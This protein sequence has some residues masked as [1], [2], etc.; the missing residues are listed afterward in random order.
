MSDECYIL[1]GN[2]PKDLFKI[3]KSLQNED[4]KTFGESNISWKK[5]QKTLSFFEN[6]SNKNKIKPYFIG[7]SYINHINYI[8]NIF[9]CN[10]KKIFVH[11][12]FEK[13]F[14]D[15]SS[16]FGYKDNPFLNENNDV[17][18]NYSFKKSFSYKDYFKKYYLEIQD[19][20]DVFYFDQ[21]IIREDFYSK[22]KVNDHIK[23]FLDLS[24]VFYMRL[25]K[26]RDSN[27]NVKKLLNK[28]QSKNEKNN[29]TFDILFTSFVRPQE[30]RMFQRQT[31]EFLNSLTYLNKKTNSQNI[32]IKWRVHF[33]LS[34]F[35]IDWESS[36]IEKDFLYSSFY[37]LKG[38]VDKYLDV[39]FTCFNDNI[40]G[41]NDL[42]RN[43]IKTYSN[44]CDAFVWLDPDVIFS[45]NILKEIN[46]HLSYIIQNNNYFA[47]NPELLYSESKYLDPIVSNKSLNIDRENFQ[48]MEIVNNKSVYLERIKNLPIS[49]SFSIISS[50]FLSLTGIPKELGHYG[51]DDKYIS[52]CFK[53][54]NEKSNEDISLYKLKNLIV[55]QIR[56][57]VKNEKSFSIYFETK[58]NEDTNKHKLHKK[59]QDC[60]DKL[61]NNFEKKVL[62][63]E[64]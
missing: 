11:S 50:S 30:F 2:N 39:D 16:D 36:S 26:H 24:P 51:N 25:K 23:N 49:G 13:F 3:E 40:H 54:F 60:I 42:R 29:N 7:T 35:Y 12:D 43:V 10:V 61:T 44:D 47:I 38:K 5:S 15:I 37:E 59:T 64:L 9:D 21:H 1:T 45:K 6:V 53:I 20:L 32:K 52:Q 58:K 57:R 34:D 19:K 31:H 18:P 28:N 22:S 41:C 33:D 63:N 4:I 27:Y 8:N 62:N 46:D 55:T 17:F 14:D 56:E 48:D